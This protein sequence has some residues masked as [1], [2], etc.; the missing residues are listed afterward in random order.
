MLLYSEGLPGQNMHMMIQ[1]HTAQIHLHAC[2]YAPVHAPTLRLQCR[3][4]QSCYCNGV[5][6]GRTMESKA[7]DLVLALAS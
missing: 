3:V 1:P 2:Q 4:V 5:S 6:E 7:I